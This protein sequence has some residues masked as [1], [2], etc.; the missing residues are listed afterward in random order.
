VTGKEGSALLAD[1]EA[2][3]AKSFA[4]GRPF[5]S[6]EKLVGD[7]GRAQ[8]A[9]SRTRTQQALAKGQDAIGVM[10]A[11]GATSLVT[12][13]FFG[14]WMLRNVARPLDRMPGA[15]EA[16]LAGD[17]QRRLEDLVG[18][19]S[20]CRIGRG[21]NE[22]VDR[23]QRVQ[24]ERGIEFLLACAA[25]ERLLDAMGEAGALLTPGKRLVAANEPAREL[26]R[27]RDAPFEDIHASMLE[28]DP[29]S[30]KEMP[31]WAPGGL[32]LGDL[33]CIRGDSGRPEVSRGPSLSPEKAG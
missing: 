30:V 27:A 31:L 6:V 8:D 20:V 17:H 3:S 1:L 29:S 13:L 15:L 33:V 2:E 7:L 10:V 23:L 12:V 25:V 19:L 14:Y 16:I 22:L 24:S 5:Q 11:L 18:S 32:R 26:I 9:R 28:A 21:V 4:G